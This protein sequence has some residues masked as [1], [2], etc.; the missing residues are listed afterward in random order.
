MLNVPLDLV[1][2]VVIDLLLGLDITLHLLDFSLDFVKLLVADRR[3]QKLSMGLWEDDS[4]D[5]S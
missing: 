4:L 1:Q 3:R 5:L 2:V